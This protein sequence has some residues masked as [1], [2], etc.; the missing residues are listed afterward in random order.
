[1]KYAIAVVA[2]LAL[3]VALYFALI[4]KPAS[5]AV[6]TA[7]SGSAI[8]QAAVGSSTPGSGSGSGSAKPRVRKIDPA[9]RTTML[10]AIRK[11]AT[12]LHHDAGST[13]GSSASGAKPELPAG[14]IPKE[15]IRASVREIIPLLQEC[16]E[17]ELEKEP[18]LGGNLTVEF[19]IEGEDGVGGVVGESKIDD[20]KSTIKSAAM[21]ECIQETMYAIEIQPPEGGGVVHVRYPFEFRTAEDGSN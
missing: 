2:V 1:M 5:V 8:A 20:E 6:T 15:F 18:K 11:R 4:R 16:Y 13:S 17:A 3:A 14:T 21:C 12:E 7:G 19:T 10:E 9:L